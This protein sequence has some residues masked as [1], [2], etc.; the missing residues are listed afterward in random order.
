MGKGGKTNEVRNEE[1]GSFQEL[2]SFTAVQ[3]C[4]SKEAE[5]GA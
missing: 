5:V 4:L 3:P 2:T 1:P